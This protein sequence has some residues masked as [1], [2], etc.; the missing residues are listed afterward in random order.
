M[1]RQLSA[2]RERKGKTTM[3]NDFS[4]TQDLSN[5]DELIEL[6]AEEPTHEGNVHSTKSSSMSSTTIAS[7]LDYTSRDR[8]PS[9]QADADAS[10]VL[11]SAFNDSMIYVPCIC[12]YYCLLLFCR[13]VYF[14]ICEAQQLF[15]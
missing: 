4:P 9:L 6:T 11:I 7:D 12:F 10:K 14:S 13:F 3:D 8:Q 5:E 15:T 2:V 1:K